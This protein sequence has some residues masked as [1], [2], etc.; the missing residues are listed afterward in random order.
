MDSTEVPPNFVT[1]I[2][3]FTN[4]LTTTFPEYS[5]RWNNLTGTIDDSSR[6]EIYKYCVT[7]YPE[8]FFDILYQNAD[9]FSDK[10]DVNV[11][12]LPNVDFK[13]L[14]N[15]EGVTENIRKTIWKYLQLVLFTVVGSVKDKSTFGDSMNMFEGI[16]EK[17]L[18][19]KLG[20]TMEGLND[21]FKDMGKNESSEGESSTG[22]EQSMPFNMNGMP[23][24]ENMQDHLHTLFNGKIGSLA[25]EM[26]EEISGDF[27]ELLG[28]NAEDASPQD[29]M[30]KLMK[31][32][33]KIMGLMKSVTGKLDAKMKSGEISREEIMKEA[34]DLLGKMKESTGGAEMSEMFAKMAKSMGGMGKNMRMDTNAIDR[35]VKSTKLKEDMSN[36]LDIKKA[37]M[38]EKAKQEAVLL[39]QRIDEQNKLIAKY[40]LEQKDGNNMVFKLDGE[41]SQEKS[42]IH[43]DLLTELEAD[44]TNKQ[45]K[46]SKPKK[47]KKKGKK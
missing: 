24:M 43:P 34:G 21:F 19:E 39:Q 27:T 15:S 38:L 47:K 35:M 10:Q 23:N 20:E 9:I 6:D 3:D 45:N 2:N 13:I 4:D 5:D 18:Q 14:Y 31:N 25:K 12:F 7:V 16:D 42:F 32:P 29:V 1:V 11:N 22:Q 41:T 44:D 17:D 30:K 26:A 40:S 37:N 33:T 46:T 36:R 8:R 28:D